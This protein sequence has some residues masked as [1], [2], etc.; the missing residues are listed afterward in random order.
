MK[1][2]QN[3]LKVLYRRCWTIYKTDLKI[4]DLNFIRKERFCWKI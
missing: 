4:G 2:Y 3:R 1:F